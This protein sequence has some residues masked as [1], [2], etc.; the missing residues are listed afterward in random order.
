MKPDD[1]C[2]VDCEGKQLAG[3][4]KRTSEIMMHLAIMKRQPEAKA[5]CH[6]TRRTAPPSPSRASSRPTCMIPEAEVF[7]GKIGLAEYQTPG[8]PANAEDVGEVGVDH[9]AVLM[10][11]HGVITWG[12]DVEDAYWKMEN[13]ESYCQ[14]VWVAAQ[15]NGGKVL[16]HHRWPGQGTHR[17]AQI[18]RHGRQARQL[19]GMRTLRQLRLPA[20]HRL[21]GAHRGGEQRLRLPGKGGR[22]TGSPD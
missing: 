6:A 2:L 18:P 16:T 11:N 10:V 13:V 1:M 20:R 12:K 5:C 14:T 19:E 9:M 21:P 7:L 3:T 17:S 22:E 8:T 15:L 4:C